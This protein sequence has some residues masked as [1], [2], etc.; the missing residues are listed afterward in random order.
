MHPLQV[1][2]L[3]CALRHRIESSGT[4]F[5]SQICKRATSL[6]S[7]L[8]DTRH[9]LMK[10]SNEEL[11]GR[12]EKRGKRNRRMKRFMTQET[13]RGFYLRRDCW[14]FRHR[15]ECRPVHEGC[16]S[17]SALGPPL[18]Y[19]P[20]IPPSSRDEGLRLLHGLATNLATSLQTPQEAGLP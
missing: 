11:G 19:N 17:H 18:E 7:L 9:F 14:F 6:N 13:A 5:L 2:M 16:S 3:L 20:E 15:T 8:C 12:R 1:A 4:V 10:T